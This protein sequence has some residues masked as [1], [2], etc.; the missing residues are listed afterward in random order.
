MTTGMRFNH[1]STF[2]AG[3]LIRKT[4]FLTVLFVLF[5]TT[6]ISRAQFAIGGGYQ[7][8]NESPKTGFTIIAE[9]GFL[10]RFPLLTLKTR[11]HFSAFSDQL[12]LKD[13]E[14]GDLA[15]ATEAQLS[16]LHDLSSYDYGAAVLFGLNL[17][18]VS[19]YV[20]AGLGNETFE[21]KYKFTDVI[22]LPGSITLDDI[23]DNG[24]YWNGFVGADVSP[25][26]FLKPFFEYRFSGV[27]GEE[28]G[29]KE[30]NYTQNGRITVGLKIQF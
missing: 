12:S 20:G 30:I 11:V 15:Q 29:A 13:L 22:S 5:L 26:P 16:A 1:L 28:I 2:I 4:L 27:L 23:S 25:I 7:L 17:G 9:Q 10:G 19:P 24:F 18:L 21:L 14:A 3:N 6:E 8:R